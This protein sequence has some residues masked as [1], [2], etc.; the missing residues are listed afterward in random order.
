[1]YQNPFE[2]DDNSFALNYRDNVALLKFPIA[3]NP[4]PVG[5][6]VTDGEQFGL[7]HF[8]HTSG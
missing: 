6:Q 7:S 3:I 4:L 1:M 5:V 8:P 2:N